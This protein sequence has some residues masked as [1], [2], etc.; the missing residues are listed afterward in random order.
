MKNVFCGLVCIA[1]LLFSGCE[2]AG[3]A[4]GEESVSS[5]SERVVSEYTLGVG[6]EL[7]VIVFGEDNLS[8]EF[9]VD[10]SGSVSLPLI[11]EVLA[12]GQ[13]LREFQ[14][15]VEARLLDGYLKDPRVS[16]DVLNFRPF[17]I[18]GEVGNSGEYPYANGLTVLNAV[19]TAGGFTYRANKK[20]VFIKR[21]GELTEVRYPLTVSTPVQPGD[22]IRIAERLF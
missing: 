1:G 21:A 15:A 9:V 11:G 5:A 12:S 20:A 3:I 6:D 10:S 18:L 8:G 14:K 13:T 17:Y 19:A 22:T 16:M 2:T 7:R 4:S